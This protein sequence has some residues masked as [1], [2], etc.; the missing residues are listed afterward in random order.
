MVFSRHRVEVTLRRPTWRYPA[1]A[2]M[3]SLFG[4][5][6]RSGRFPRE[7]AGPLDKADGRLSA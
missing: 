5:M 2:E 3:V 6:R 4:R 1:D 7:R